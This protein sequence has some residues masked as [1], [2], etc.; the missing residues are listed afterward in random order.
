MSGSIGVPRVSKKELT[1][2][3]EFNLAS[4]QRAAI[5]AAETEQERQRKLKEEEE[6]RNFKA[7]P[8]PRDILDLPEPVAPVKGSI[9]PSAFVFRY[10]FLTHVSNGTYEH[11]A[12]VRHSAQVA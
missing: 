4:E 12:Q 8:A 5:K 6:A 3:E 11:S 1:I 7:R 9:P 10:C 2:P